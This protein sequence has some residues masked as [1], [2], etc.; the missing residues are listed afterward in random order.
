M[1]QCKEYTFLIPAPTK[2]GRINYI[3]FQATGFYVNFI[4]IGIDEIVI[5]NTPA[6]NVALA[7][8]ILSV[9]IEAKEASEQYFQNLYKQTVS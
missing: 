6:I 7:K 5:T 9:V 2:D 1:K 3:T 4:F 8:D